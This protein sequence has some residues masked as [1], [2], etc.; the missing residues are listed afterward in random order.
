L[1]VFG[2]NCQQDDRS[3]RE[4]MKNGIM[5]RAAEPV[6]AENKFGMR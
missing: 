2:S 4:Q 1:C 5:V 3:I 6:Q